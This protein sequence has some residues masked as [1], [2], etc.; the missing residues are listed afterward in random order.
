MKFHE[1]AIL[2]LILFSIVASV[3]LKAFSWLLVY[4]WNA[5]WHLSLINEN[6]GMLLY[7][8]KQYYFIVRS[9]FSK[10]GPFYVFRV[11]KFSSFSGPSSHTWWPRSWK[12]LESP[13]I[14]FL[15]WKILEC[16]GIVLNFE[17]CPGFVLENEM[18]L[19][20]RNN[21]LLKHF[22]IFLLYLFTP[23]LLTSRFSNITWSWKFLEIWSL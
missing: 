7:C 8:G 20:F 9:L 16:P 21:N 18:I 19:F 2:V 22:I 10:G 13:G 23:R 5:L 1:S 14:F 11:I 17:I 12:I 4:P 6:L 15:S 3:F